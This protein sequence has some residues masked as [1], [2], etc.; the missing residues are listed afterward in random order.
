MNEKH[1]LFIPQ[2]LSI[3]NKFEIIKDM[4]VLIS[5][6]GRLFC[7]KETKN[8]IFFNKKLRTYFLTKQAILNKIFNKNFLKL[9]NKKF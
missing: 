5:S 8:V 2:S 7:Y 6:C 1:F 9:W 4:F 3:F